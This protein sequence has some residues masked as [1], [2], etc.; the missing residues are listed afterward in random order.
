MCSKV[1]CD[2][3]LVSKPANASV[4]EA[5]NNVS[6]LTQTKSNTVVMWL[7]LRVCAVY[8][9][10][11]HVCIVCVGWQCVYVRVCALY[12]CLLVKYEMALEQVTNDVK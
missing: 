5:A 10:S 2:G 7:L 1:G 4:I 12:P 11:V 9:F 3:K 6:G 8:V